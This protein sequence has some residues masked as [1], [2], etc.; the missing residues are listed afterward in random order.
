ME[1]CIQ[2]FKSSFKICNPGESEDTYTSYSAVKDAA[3][4]G[5]DVEVVIEAGK[6]TLLEGNPDGSFYQ[7]IK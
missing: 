7:V 2:T 1:C 4:T 3:L 5:H 6:C